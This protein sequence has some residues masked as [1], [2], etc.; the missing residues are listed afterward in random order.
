MN[1][2]T[3]YSNSYGAPVGISIQQVVEGSAAEKAGLKKYDIITKFD[4]QTVTSMT[5]LQ[6]LLQY[7]KAGETVIITVEYMENHEYAEREVEI[8]LGKAIE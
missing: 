1:I 8:T 7:Y 3:A 4:G 5:E 2:D 6:N